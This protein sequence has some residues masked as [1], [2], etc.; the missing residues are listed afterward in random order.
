MVKM[1]FLEFLVFAPK[2]FVRPYLSS[3]TWQRSHS[4]LKIIVW[5]SSLLTNTTQHMGKHNKSTRASDV[6][7]IENFEHFKIFPLLYPKINFL[8]VKGKQ[9]TKYIN[10]SQYPS[11]ISH[12]GAK[13]M[14][15]WPIYRN[16]SVF[17]QNSGYFDQNE[18]GVKKCPFP[19]SLRFCHNWWASGGV[20]GV[21]YAEK[22]SALFYLHWESL[23]PG[24]LAFLCR[25]DSMFRIHS[26]PW[27]HQSYV[28]RPWQQGYIFATLASPLCYFFRKK[29]A[30]Q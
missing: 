9:L 20:P 28:T 15:E 14:I 21:R 1:H 13:R 12:W 2:N 26:G 4:V 22:L 6:S 11:K 17:S 30:S 8:D 19:Q 27:L 29:I 23:W 18:K 5:I 3:P 24:V 16:F 7:L 25:Y 10:V